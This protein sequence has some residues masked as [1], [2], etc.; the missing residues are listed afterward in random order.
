MKKHRKASISGA[1]GSL[2]ENRNFNSEKYRVGWNKGSEKDD[3]ITGITGS[4]INTYFREF[5]TRLART[6]SLDP[7]F[8]PWQSSYSSMDNNPIWFNDPRGDKIKVG[9]KD[10]TAKS[11]IKSLAKNKNQK[12]V[13]FG[14][15]GNVSLNF[16]GLKQQKIDKILKKD[17]G[18]SLIKDLVGAKDASGGDV[19]FFYGTEGATGIGLENSAI[20]SG[21]N[22]YYSD[23]NSLEGKTPF[24][25]GGYN[26][27][28]FVLNASKQ[29]YSS[30]G[31][32][33]DGDVNKGY[34][35][36]PTADYD[37]KVFIGQGTFKVIGKW[38]PS[39]IN[40]SGQ[41]T[42]Y[43]PMIVVPRSSI[44]KHELQ[45]SLFRT[46]YGNCYNIAHDKAIPVKTDRYYPK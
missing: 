40:E 5:D 38:Q 15:D 46:L 29:Q 24:S 7:V 45:E 8:Q 6:W 22:N 17:E 20:Q 4:H 36:V 34:G 27:Q 9:A 43:S 33:Y 23:V 35:L 2:L 28:G 26:P 39:A 19:N 3:E 32:S 21:F 13:G 11:D 30:D 14:A 1:F 18:L 31:K 44:V 37:A 12:Y 42:W 25:D 10:E 16:G 41:R